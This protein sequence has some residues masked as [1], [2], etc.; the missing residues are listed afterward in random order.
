MNKTLVRLAHEYAIGHDDRRDRILGTKTFKKNMDQFNWL[1]DMLTGCEYEL[2]EDNEYYHEWIKVKNYYDSHIK[3][4]ARNIRGDKYI[5]VHYYKEYDENR[6][7]VIYRKLLF[8]VQKKDV[9][10]KN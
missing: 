6:V 8:I 9:L 3:V 4:K 10:F 7:E 2:E 5:D 1:V